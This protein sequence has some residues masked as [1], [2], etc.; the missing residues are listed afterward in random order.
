MRVMALP[1]MP[2]DS[3]DRLPTNDD[4]L[5]SYVDIVKVI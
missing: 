5:A 4:E 1:A 2:L 3:F